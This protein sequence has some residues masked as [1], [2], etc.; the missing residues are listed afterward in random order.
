M[1]NRAMTECKSK[2]MRTK[3]NGMQGPE[4]LLT[5]MPQVFAG[6][7]KEAWYGRPGVR[8]DGDI[9]HLTEWILDR[10]S[11]NVIDEL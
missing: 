11:S 8:V 1:Q 9:E 2:V 4:Q 7:G 5:I 6:R 10:Q 3:V